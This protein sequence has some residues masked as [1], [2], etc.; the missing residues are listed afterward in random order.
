MSL[1][2]WETSPQFELAEDHQD[3]GLGGG[4]EL[5]RSTPSEM[6]GSPWRPRPNRSPP[7]CLFSQGGCQS[8]SR[9]EKGIQ[10]KPSGFRGLDWRK[11]PRLFQKRNRIA[12]NLTARSASRGAESG[13]IPWGREEFHTPCGCRFASFGKNLG[14]DIRPTGISM[15]AERSCP[16]ASRTLSPSSSALVTREPRTP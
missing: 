5:L 11:C 8:A 12:G 9:L 7:G 3:E 4:G 10:R 6:A 14:A 16:S 1:K 15:R 13:G 2:P